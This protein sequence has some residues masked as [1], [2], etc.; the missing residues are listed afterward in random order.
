MANDL[1]GLVE[2]EHDLTGSLLLAL[3]AEPVELAGPVDVAHDLNA[4]LTIAGP[5]G[6][7][8]GQ[9]GLDHDLNA[10]LTAA[11]GGPAELAGQLDVGHDLTA[12]LHAQTGNIT[13]TVE[14]LCALTAALAS[15]PPPV[16]GEF[17]GHVDLVHT[18]TATLRVVPPAPSGS[19]AYGRGRAKAPTLVSATVTL[20]APADALVIPGT[21]PI[22]TITVVTRQSGLEAVVEY[23]AD[24]AFTSPT[25][26]VTPI[27]PGQPIIRVSLRATTALTDGGDYFWRAFVRNANDATPATTPRTFTVS[28]PDGEGVASGSWTVTTATTPVPHLWFAY[29]ARAKAGDTAMAYGTG[30]GPS[31]VTATVGGVE[32]VVT[33]VVTVAPTTD[34]YTA[35]RAVTAATAHADPGH[36]RVTFTVP[37]APAPGGVL[38]LDGS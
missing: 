11:T 34:A 22:F 19:L 35:G 23:A 28:V 2:I 13:G 24:S 4:A 33:G 10:T 37:A 26:L 32:A 20:V 27:A 30:F 8:T 31:H 7:F 18:L 14:L 6:V 9:T 29:P 15:G 16:P 5:P 17:A 12:D 1:T 25:L 36:Q 38:Y 21:K 3:A